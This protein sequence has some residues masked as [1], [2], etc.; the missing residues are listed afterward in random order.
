MDKSSLK[1]KIIERIS[2]IEEEIIDLKNSTRPVAP[3]V[4]I[5]RVS[6]MDAIN[7]RSVAEASLRNLEVKLEGLQIA[8]E[9]INKPN[10]G[11]CVKCRQPIPEG[12]ILLM[13]EKRLC[14][15]CS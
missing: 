11:I 7:N 10:F 3:D 14:V 1:V 6:R 8:L 4:A 12:R 5:G 13:P 2:K 15:K 9:N